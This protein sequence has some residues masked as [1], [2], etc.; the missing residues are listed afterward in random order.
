M[1]LVAFVVLSFFILATEPICGQLYMWTDKKGVTHVSDQPPDNNSEI[2]ETIKYEENLPAQNNNVKNNQN[3][4]ELKK[5]IAS[6]EKCA[7]LFREKTALIKEESVLSS[8]KYEIAREL[9]KLG[10]E[11][12]NE[13]IDAKEKTV[14]SQQHDLQM[15]QKHI[16]FR[17]GEYGCYKYENELKTNR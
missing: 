2:K 8:K 16:N 3:I 17:L 11:N 13:T 5:E 7:E 10:V 14:T 9:V 15:R 1:K 12:R 6:K 4:D